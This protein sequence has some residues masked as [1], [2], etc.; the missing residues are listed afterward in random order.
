MHPIT[1]RK[2]DKLKSQIKVYENVDSIIETLAH[3]LDTAL[4]DK[5]ETYNCSLALMPHAIAIFWHNAKL[6][7]DVTVLLEAARMSGWHLMS[8]SEQPSPADGHKSWMMRNVNC[9][10][11]LDIYAEFSSTDEDCCRFVRTGIKEVPVFAFV[12]PEGTPKLVT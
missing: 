11:P 12:C 8:E 1:Q 6:V 2:I 5:S 7:S 10:L 9:D 3:A 4:E